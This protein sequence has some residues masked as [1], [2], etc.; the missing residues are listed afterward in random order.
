MTSFLSLAHADNACS[1]KPMSTDPSPIAAS[2]PPPIYEWVASHHARFYQRLE[3]DHL[4][5]ATLLSSGQ[6]QGVDRYAKTLAHMSLCDYHNRCGDC[7][8]CQLIAAGEHPDLMVIEPQLPSKLIRIAQVRELI[9]FM[10]LAPHT[11]SRKIGIV[12][13]IDRMNIESSNALL[14]VLE[15]PPSGRYLLA[16]T[17][18][19][20]GLLPTIKSRLMME[21]IDAP[22]AQQTAAFINAR[23]S[24]DEY[25]PATLELA[26]SR[27]PHAPA[28]AMM[29]LRQQGEAIESDILTWLLDVLVYDQRRI[30]PALGDLKNQITDNI[31]LQQ[32]YVF[33]IRSVIQQIIAYET[34]RFRQCYVDAAMMEALSGRLSLSVWLNMQREVDQ[35]NRQLGQVTVSSRMMA[36]VHRVKVQL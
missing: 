2:M 16:T 24:A 20:E 4:N 25:L 12:H 36:I 17:H 31:T 8:S 23:V 27:Y 35:I 29:F 1:N 6:G 9:E 34:G 21:A 18:Y 7:K 3:Q 15:E 28:L 26:I 13:Q 19:A 32:T 22:S 10:S 5:H 33:Y 11:S 30:F 14:K